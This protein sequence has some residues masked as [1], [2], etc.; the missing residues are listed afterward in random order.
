MPVLS[1]N[2]SLAAGESAVRP[3][4]IRNVA[5]FRLAFV[6]LTT[7]GLASW[8]PPENRAGFEVLDPVETLQRLLPEIAAAEA[9]RGH[10]S[11]ATWALP[12]VTILPTASAL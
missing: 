8:L 2:S 10:S 4:V 12:A 5:G 1:A 11:P 6:G 7:P 9:G 3:Y